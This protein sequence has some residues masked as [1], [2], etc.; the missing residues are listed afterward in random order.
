[1]D[2][3]N[4]TSITLALGIVGLLWLSW[5]RSV[6]TRITLSEADQSDGPDDDTG[7]ED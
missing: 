4:I 7:G 6:A 2:W 3:L 1:M 5:Q